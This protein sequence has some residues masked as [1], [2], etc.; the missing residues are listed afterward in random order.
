MYKLI[1][2]TFQLPRNIQER[3]MLSFWCCLFQNTF[4]F[5]H[6]VILSLQSIGSHTLGRSIYNSP[7]LYSIM[8][9]Y[10]T[11]TQIL[12]H[13]RIAYAQSVHTVCNKRCTCCVCIMS[14]A[15]VS[16]G[17]G[18]TLAALASKVT[19]PGGCQRQ[20]GCVNVSR[21]LCKPLRSQFPTTV[22]YMNSKTF[23]KSKQ[24][25]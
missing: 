24:G 3:E 5:Y 21:P 10:N 11:C 16:M 9:I 7:P 18:D 1:V 14:L 19:L 17:R 2:D 6:T 20:W 8:Y 15:C 22:Q 25:L 12:I 13:M 4:L 23:L